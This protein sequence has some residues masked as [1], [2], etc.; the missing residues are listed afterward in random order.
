[1]C[2]KRSDELKRRVYWI[3][4]YMLDTSICN[5]GAA[6]FFAISNV[7]DAPSNATHFACRSLTARFQKSSLSLGR[8][9]KCVN[10][11][12]VVRG[13]EISY[14]KVSAEVLQYWGTIVAMQF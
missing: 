5:G 11:K 12:I 13:V 2:E 8:E 7:T 9:E 6:K 3:F 1:M 4:K 10:D 14:K